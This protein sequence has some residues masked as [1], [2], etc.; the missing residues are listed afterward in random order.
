MYKKE[1]PRLNKE[2]FP[3]W[4]SLMGVYLAGIGDGEI[5]FVENSYVEIIVLPIIAQQLKEKEEHDQAILEIASALSYT[6]F[7]DIKTYK[8][9]KEMWDTLQTIYGG[10]KN[11]PREKLESLRGKFDDM[12]MKEDEIIVKYFTRIKEVVNAIKGKIGNIDDETMISKVL[13]ILLPIYIIRVSTI[14]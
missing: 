7:D 2:N 10:D 6:K 9:V 13:K 4:K 1:V 5:H 14:Q 12:R 8:N 3:T 11:V